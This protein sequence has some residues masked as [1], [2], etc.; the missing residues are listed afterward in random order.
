[1]PLWFSGFTRQHVIL[2]DPQAYFCVADTYAGAA[3]YGED[4]T[5]CCSSRR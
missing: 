1:M 5:Y 2:G 3:P 4:L